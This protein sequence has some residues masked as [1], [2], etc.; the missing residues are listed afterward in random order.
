M[1]LRSKAFVSF[2]ILAI[3]Y[4]SIN[5]IAA[6][7]RT[8]LQRYHI[9]SSSLRLLDSTVVL[10][11]VAIWFVGLYGYQ[12]LNAYAKYV[13]GNEEGSA[14]R[15]LTRGISL[16]AFWL[17]V[18]STFS[19][20]LSFIT[21][22]HHAFLPVSTI[23]TNYLSMLFPLAAFFYINRGSRKLS[24][25]SHSRPSQTGIH[26]M[27]AILIAA[28]VLYGYFV[29]NARNHIG[30]LYHMPLVLV[31]CTLVMPYIF[32]WYLG[33]LATYDMHTYTQHV[34][35]VI[36]R[37]SWNALAFGMVWIILFSIAVQY[38]TTVSSKFSDLSLGWILAMIYTLIPI[39]ALGYIFVAIGAKRL[40][41][42]EEV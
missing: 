19:S 29:A 22:H 31:L 10:P 6:P 25:L 37:K 4:A 24:E 17:P 3:I 5:L 28:G 16:L 7:P 32:S 23:T 1:K 38:I 27:A 20:V 21:T 42:I 11:M 41:K 8:T 35:G 36:F 34:E 13:Q 15:S 2:V 12:K 30:L 26:G 33:L 18:S 9:S 14:L 40:T 39:L